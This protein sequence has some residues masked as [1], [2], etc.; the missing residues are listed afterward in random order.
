MTRILR[1]S[2]RPF[3]EALWA[4]D[5]TGR[6]APAA[7]RE[8]V[9]PTGQMH[10]VFL[11]ADHPLRLFDSAG[12]SSGHTLENGVVGGAR[13][14]FYIREVAGPLCSVGVQLRSG[15]ARP[16]F[17]VPADELAGRH[18]LLEDLWGSSVLRIR[19]QLVE[20]PDLERRLDVLEGLLAARLPQARALHPAVARALERLSGASRVAD[21]VNESGYSHR[22]FISL[23]RESVGLS[24]KQYCRVIRFQE[25]LRR[26]ASS[27]AASLTD[28]AIETGYSDQAHFTREFRELVG[29]TPTEYRAISPHSSHHLRVGPPLVS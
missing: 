27:R 12:D 8:H 16:L 29:V 23:F 6:P 10:L 13:S 5:E 21:L 14:A 17:G 25:A 15:A 22:T 3:V 2:L 19:E 18:T 20:C 24:P 1:P 9:L 11:L 28:V 26:C 4:I 7:R